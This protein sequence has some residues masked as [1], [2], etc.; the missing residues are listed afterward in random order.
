[1]SY[2]PRRLKGIHP[3][4]CTCVDWEERRKWRLPRGPRSQQPPAAPP[5]KPP[6][7]REDLNRRGRVPSSTPQT[8]S[9]SGGEPME[10]ESVSEW[11]KV[12]MLE[13][14]Q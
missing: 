12:V 14:W 5:P 3:D 4:A 9:R 11:E 7:T 6:A 13:L 10:V 8:G 2:D 1:M